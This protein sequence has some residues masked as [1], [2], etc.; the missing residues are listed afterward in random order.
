M[1]GIVFPTNASSLGGLSQFY[2]W[3]DG[4]GSGNQLIIQLYDSGKNYIA[5]TQTIDWTGWKRLF[6]PLYQPNYV[7]LPMNF[8]YLHIISATYY[9]D[10]TNIVATNSTVVTGPPETLG[11]GP[12]MGPFR[13]NRGSHPLN[14]PTDTVVLLDQSLELRNY[15]SL[16]YRQT[17]T[18]QFSINV[19][20]STRPFPLI[21]G[22]SFNKNWKAC[23]S[24]SAPID[25]VACLPESDHFVANDYAN[26]WI[27]KKTGSFALTIFFLP[28]VV[29]R[30][31][32]GAS[33]IAW[34]IMAVV[35]LAPI[36]VRR[37]LSRIRLPTQG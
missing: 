5:F 25:L 33:V 37:R 18:N 26:G 11:G 23:V 35:V 16:A 17:G 21:F 9:Y 34:I 32:I 28:D 20:N 14:N 4:D 31:A 10:N 13:L 2:V 30:F 29:E 27:I 7:G 12:S 3:V 6:L 1:R 15:P 22:E 19:Y 36:G 24:D 8:D